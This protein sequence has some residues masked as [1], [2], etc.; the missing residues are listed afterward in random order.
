MR[1]FGVDREL[2]SATVIS[3]NHQEFEVRVPDELSINS[4]QKY[5]Q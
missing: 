3:W 5:E 2:G 4:N 1:A